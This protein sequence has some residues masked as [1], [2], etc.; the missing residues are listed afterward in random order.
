[1]MKEVETEFINSI[2]KELKEMLFDNDD[3]LTINGAFFLIVLGITLTQQVLK[4]LVEM[5]KCK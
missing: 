3:N 1:M 4:R 5:Q 2:N